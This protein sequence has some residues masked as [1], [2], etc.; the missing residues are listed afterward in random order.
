MVRLSSI[1]WMLTLES[2]HIIYAVLNS[3]SDKGILIVA[4]EKELCEGVRSTLLLSGLAFP[5]L[6]RS[7]RPNS[8]DNI[9]AHVKGE[10]RGFEKK[11]LFPDILQS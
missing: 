7:N 2:C 9:S 1:C 3:E 11:A 10:L 5:L 8:T 4:Y 6:G